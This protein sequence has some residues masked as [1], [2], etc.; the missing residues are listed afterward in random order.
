[1]DPDPGWTY[2]D[3]TSFLKV[4]KL[5][6]FLNFGQ[7]QCSCIRIRIRKFRIPNSDPDLGPPN[8]CGSVSTTL[9]YSIMFKMPAADDH[10]CIY[11]L[12]YE[13]PC[14]GIVYFNK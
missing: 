4:R 8:Q 11:N 2:E 7:C 3:T 13:F 9:H 6:L 10:V 5:G 12:F 14:I 1:M